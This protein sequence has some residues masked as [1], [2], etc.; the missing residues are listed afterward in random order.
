MPIDEDEPVVVIR[1]STFEAMLEALYEFAG[2]LHKA[3][4][5]MSEE[6]GVDPDHPI[7]QLVPK[8]PKE[9]GH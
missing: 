1:W 5:E 7:L 6:L 9:E 8:P 2:V 3:V 4:D